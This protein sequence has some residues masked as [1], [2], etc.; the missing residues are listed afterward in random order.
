MDKSGEVNGESAEKLWEN[1]NPKSTEMYKFI[2]HVNQ[3][4]S[5]N[6]SS[7]DDLYSWSIQETSEFWGEVWNYTGMKGS[8]YTRVSPAHLTSDSQL[9]RI[10]C[11]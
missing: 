1:T 10:G 7:Y 4:Y 3:K 8:D 5:K 6:I 11:R 2:Q 9:S